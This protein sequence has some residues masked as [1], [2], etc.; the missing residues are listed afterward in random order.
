MECWA[1][2]VGD[3]SDVK[4]VGTS[5]PKSPVERANS[6]FS[7]HYPKVPEVPPSST[8]RSRQFKTPTGLAVSKAFDSVS[9]FV[10]TQKTVEEF[11]E[12]FQERLSEVTAPSRD[13]S[14]PTK[15]SASDIQV[16]LDLAITRRDASG[17]DAI[18]AVSDASVYLKDL[19]ESDQERMK[20]GL[21]SLNLWDE[22]MRSKKSK[23]LRG[24][25]TLF[26]AEEAN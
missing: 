12:K 14:L 26:I 24:K 23:R 15:A 20:E 21:A 2:K 10:A 22:T 25:H 13:F 19:S 9:H 5:T 7:A 3:T 8:R 1:T 16:Q 17:Y 18:R 6:M 11:E 4:T